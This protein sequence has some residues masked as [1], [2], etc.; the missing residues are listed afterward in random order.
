MKILVCNVGSSSLKMK[1]LDMRT[2]TV[3]ANCIIER[4]GHENAVTR[5]F[6]GTRKVINKESSIKNYSSGIK[7]VLEYLLD[8]RFSIINNLNEISAVGFKT[9]QAGDKNGTVLVTDEIIQAME[10]FTGLAPAHNPPYLQA[11]DVFRNLL[12]QIPLVGVFEPGFHINAPTY[13]K[14][15]GTPIDWL[16]NHGVKK[17]GYHGASH[18]YIWDKTRELLN[19]PK[20]H[21]IISCHLGGSTSLC[22]IHDGI[23]IDTSMGFSPQSGIIQGTRIG[24]FDP[25]ILPYIMKR[26]GLTLEEALANC[27]ENAGLAGLSGTSGDMRDINAEIKNGSKRAK[28]AREKYIYDIKRYIGEYLVLMQGLDALTFT[29]GIGLKDSDLRQTITA[30]LA[31]L[32][33]KLDLSQ[34]RNHDQKISASDSKISVFVLETN[35]ELIVAR[36]TQKLLFGKS[37]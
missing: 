33:C 11:I 18:Q 7:T 12:P 24:D 3:L 32:G 5:I 20:K 35:E 29:G 6:I 15:Y 1:L 27:S 30:S 16:E 4:V 14:V 21:K 10:N 19:Q 34:N 23:A 22:A 36:E 9:V 25:Y 13:A 28:L 2:E 31:F 8:S 26:K 17:Y 37:A